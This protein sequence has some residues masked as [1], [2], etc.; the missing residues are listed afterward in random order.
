VSK[1][2]PKEGVDRCPGCSHEL[3]EGCCIEC[4]ECYE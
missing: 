4:G 1:M 3:V 2:D